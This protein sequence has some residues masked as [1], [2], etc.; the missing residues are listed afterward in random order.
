LNWYK[1]G[2]EFSKANNNAIE[3]NEMKTIADKYAEQ[4]TA[5]LW[6][7]ARYLP[8]HLRNQIK[9][10]VSAVN[11]LEYYILEEGIK[12]GILY[13]LPETG[14]TEGI[15]ASIYY[16]QIRV[17]YKDAE[18]KN[19]LLE[20]Y[21]IEDVLKNGI[22]EKIGLQTDDIMIAVNGIAWRE[23]WKGGNALK[24]FNGGNWKEGDIITVE[25]NGEKIDFTI[26]F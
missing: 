23:H 14:C 26:A 15:L 21:Q 2:R 16:P 12:D 11:C 24:P 7:A 19:G 6:D 10:F 13:E 20:K 8:E 17:N 1:I 25:R 3:D 22:A 4:M 18:M 5:K 9:I